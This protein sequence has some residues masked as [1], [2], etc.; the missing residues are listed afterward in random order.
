[1]VDFLQRDEREGRI[2][3]FRRLVESKIHLQFAVRQ[4]RT[5]V[6]LMALSR[7][8]G[9][10]LEHLNITL[11]YRDTNESWWPWHGMPTQARRHFVHVAQLPD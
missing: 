6:E 9:A 10:P 5:M 3:D 11:N 7:R 2:A 8:V 4:V 1:V